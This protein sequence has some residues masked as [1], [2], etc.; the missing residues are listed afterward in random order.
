MKRF[1]IFLMAAVLV[2]T[3]ATFPAAGALPL[4]QEETVQPAALGDRTTYHICFR[5]DGRML[6][7]SG[8]VYTNQYIQNDVSMQWIFE[9]YLPSTY[10]VYSAASPSYAL[11]VDPTTCSVTLGTYTSGNNFQLW[12]LISSSSGAVLETFSSDSRVSGKKLYSSGYPFT[13][14]V[15]SSGSSLELISPSQLWAHTAMAVDDINILLG[16][17][18]EIPEPSYT[19]AS[20]SY[21]GNPWLIYSSANTSVCTVSSSGVVTPVSAGETTITVTN[22]IT[23][24]SATCPVYIPSPISL[25]TKLLYPFSAID[26]P[27]AESY[28]SAYEDALPL[29]YDMFLIEFESPTVEASY[30]LYTYIEENSHEISGICTSACG[31][32]S[33][34]DSTHHTSASRICSIEAGQWYYVT[35]IVDFPMCAYENGEHFS[36]YGVAFTG[37]RDTAV[38]YSDYSTT[39]Q[40]IMH[41]LSHNLGTHDNM[42]SS[43][44]CV[45]N[46]GTTGWCS[47]CRSLIWNHRKTI[48]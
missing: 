18:Y 28:M 22:K 34:C 11:T 43:T 30:S 41:E 26:F 35:R 10:I 27:M 33:Q 44:Q 8:S 23:R 31:E 47:N 4:E 42:C 20:A 38:Y 12:T 15:Q 3:T 2:L 37:G 39:V 25:N 45:M 17:T 1:L 21:T 19:P 40:V 6:T 32:L 48:D 46:G 5:D 24:V 29:F 7:A 16:N 14:S 13:A 9:E 36:V